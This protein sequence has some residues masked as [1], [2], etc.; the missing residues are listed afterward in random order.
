MIDGPLSALV[1]GAALGSG[2]IAGVFYAFSVI[3]MK[4]LAALPPARGIAAMQSVNVVVISPWF[5]GVFAG[6][7]LLCAAIAVVALVTR[8]GTGAAVELLLGCGL[9]LTG[10]VAVTAR[11]NVPR[12]GALAE[13][14]PEEPRSADRWRAYVASWTAW[15]HVRAGAALAACAAFV[16]ALA[17]R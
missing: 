6:T 16:L 13:L 14:D 15:N 1:L 2:L 12:N 7:G 5:L 8:P 11:A 10:T 3:V 4:A 17:G 9:Y